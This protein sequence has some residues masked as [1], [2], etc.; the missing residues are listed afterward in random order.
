MFITNLNIDIFQNILT[1]CVGTRNVNVVCSLSATEGSF[2][3][4]FSCE[5]S[6]KSFCKGDLGIIHTVLCVCRRVV[7]NGGWF[8][9]LLLLCCAGTSSTPTVCKSSFICMALK[10]QQEYLQFTHIG[11]G[12][13][14]HTADTV[15]E[16][17][18]LYQLL[19]GRVWDSILIRAQSHWLQQ[20]FNE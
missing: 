2:H 11:V 19:Q 15:L 5:Q 18:A 17:G 9:F 8:L 4:S 1:G 12:K 16:V 6:W 7:R 3:W 20:R 14:Q 10:R 13:E